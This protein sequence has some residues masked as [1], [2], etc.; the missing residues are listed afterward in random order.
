MHMHTAR[1]IECAI[2]QQRIKVLIKLVLRSVFACSAVLTTL[3]T[4]HHAGRLLIAAIFLR[5]DLMHCSMTGMHASTLC[6]F[7][8]HA[9]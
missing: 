7:H 9:L 4:S 6:I 3:L 2:E 8:S 1:M 5:S